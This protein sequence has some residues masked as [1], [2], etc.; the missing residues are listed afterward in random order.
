M[1]GFGIYVV[2]FGTLQVNTNQNLRG[3]VVCNF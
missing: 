2:L 3:E 1:A